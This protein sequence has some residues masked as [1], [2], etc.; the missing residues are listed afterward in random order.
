MLYEKKALTNDAFNFIESIRKSKFVGKT[1]SSTKVKS[2][3]ACSSGTRDSD[4]SDDGEMEIEDTSREEMK[5]G[6]GRRKVM[7]SE[8]GDESR[9]EMAQLEE[10]DATREMEQSDIENEQNMKSEGSGGSS[11]EYWVW[12][13]RAELSTSSDDDP[14]DLIEVY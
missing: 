8:E 3:Q 9:E 11:S 12:E 14:F 6:D 2:S 13:G 5:E 7:Q 4:E 10:H 1:Y